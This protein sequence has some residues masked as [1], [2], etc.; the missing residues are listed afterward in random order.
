MTDY[1]PVTDNSLLAFGGAQ[2]PRGD[3]SVSS[4]LFLGEIFEDGFLFGG[5]T[6]DSFWVST[7]GGV[8]FNGADW[9]PRPDQTFTIA[10][11]NNHLDSSNPP[12]PASGVFVD[13]NTERDSVVVTWNMIGR[14]YQNYE[15]SYTFQMELLDLGEG[16]AEV[17]FRYADMGVSELSWYRAGLTA[18]R[19]S[20]LLSSES[21]TGIPS[22]ALDDTPGNTG[23]A[24]VW[25]FR[26]V[27]GV[28][29]PGLNVDGTD[30]PDLMVG[31]AR[32]DV[33][34]GLGGDDTIQG[35]DGADVLDGGNGND[36]I[37]G[38]LSQDTIAGGAGDDTITGGGGNDQISGQDGNDTIDGGEGGDTIYGGV[39]DDLLAESWEITDYWNS[40]DRIEGGEGNDTV[41]GAYGNDTID[42]GDGN[43]E[44]RGGSDRDEMH[45]GAGNDT[46]A[47]G[48]GNDS[49]YGG[50]GDDFL[51]G[52]FGVNMA[53]GGAGA[54]TF[55]LNPTGQLT[56]VDF[57]PG[58]GDRLIV[59]GDLY[60]RNSFF[61]RAGGD[62]EIYDA[63][64]NRT[65]SS[66]DILHR[67]E[68]EPDLRLIATVTLLSGVDAVELALPSD[69]NPG[70]APIIWDFF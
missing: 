56:I 47:G 46:M 27:D 57:N 36:E 8:T 37:D 21:Y 19:G 5:E 63:D 26:I 10:P 59:D 54:D 30:G 25:Q 67:A 13:L 58:E 50:D 14:S 61:A 38:G 1:T 23:V 18:E 53:E 35:N 33:L 40:Y 9:W 16:D 11:F 69:L 15:P 65:S 68:G 70:L 20:T 39:G 64:G 49:L 42:G 22:Y 29:E 24:G 28:L 51:Y 12:D 45:G 6:F 62:G 48:D 2:V 44:L 7:N 17:I 32:A 31:T 3:G 55:L 4:E 60:A 34:N 66:L 41:Q 52:D 43:D